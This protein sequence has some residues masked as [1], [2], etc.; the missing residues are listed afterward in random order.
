MSR[1]IKFRG[2]SLVTKEEVFGHLFYFDDGRY[3]ISPK[4]TVVEGDEGEYPSEYYL[5]GVKCIEVEPETVS[6]CTGLKGYM[7][8]SF[9]D[10]GQKDV[11]QGD[12]ITITYDSCY[13]GFYAEEQYSGVVD[14]DDT[15]TAF[16]LRN[17]DYERHGE[18]IPN[19]I[20]DMEISFSLPDDD[21]L[22]QIYLH[23]FELLPENI[24]INGNIY[25]NPELL[26]ER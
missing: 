7:N 13:G 1:E 10:C 20:G 12:H 25:E 9:N 4:G 2:N 18:D 22:E 3:F 14:L 5:R 24:T 23:A 15:G 8:D 21:D 11:Y 17:A 6:Q 19:R 26:K 16:V